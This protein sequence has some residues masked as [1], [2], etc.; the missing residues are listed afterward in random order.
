M[1]AV[2]T[3]RASESATVSFTLPR[4]VR[5]PLGLP[6]ST[7]EDL[8]LGVWE[9]LAARGRAECPVCTGEIGHSGCSRCGSK[10]S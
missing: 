2:A 1:A 6:G 3:A 8:I 7:L 4:S 10:V 9:D 5:G